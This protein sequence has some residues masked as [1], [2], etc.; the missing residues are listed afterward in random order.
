MLELGKLCFTSGET[1]CASAYNCDASS[2]CRSA[3]H[4]LASLSPCFNVWEFSVGLQA[5]NKQQSGSS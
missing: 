3:A 5:L 1:V 2:D 4:L